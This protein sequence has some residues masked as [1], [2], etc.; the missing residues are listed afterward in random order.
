V[1]ELGLTGMVATRTVVDD[2]VLDGAVD[3]CVV[4]AGEKA[5]AMRRFAR[6]RGLDL[7]GSSAWGV[8]YADLPVLRAVGDPGLVGPDAMMRALAE[9]EGWPT[10]G[11]HLDGETR[12]VAGGPSAR[13]TPEEADPGQGRR[14]GRL[15]H[16]S[17]LVP[18]TG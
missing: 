15:E 5:T 4:V 9:A 1:R 16:V 17:S 2:G 18:Q 3:G 7:S 8:S 10:A 6:Q 14:S 12:I 11:D 13:D